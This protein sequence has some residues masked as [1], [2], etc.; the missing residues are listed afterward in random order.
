[1]AEALGTIIGL[2]A[3]DRQGEGSNRYSSILQAA[4]AGSIDYFKQKS[5]PVSSLIQ[6]LLSYDSQSQGPKL[7]E[8][9]TYEY[10]DY[11]S[12]GPI[13]NLPY[14]GDPGVGSVPDTIPPPLPKTGVI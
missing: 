7:G 5:G 4:K 12:Q 11:N 8:R 9:N 1:M 14:Y 6:S 2:V 3:K 13:E 10:S